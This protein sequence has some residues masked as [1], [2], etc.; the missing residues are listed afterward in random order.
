MNCYPYAKFI[1]LLPFGLL[2]AAFTSCTQTAYLPSTAYQPCVDTTN[3]FDFETGVTLFR[4]GA[5]GRVAFAVTNNLVTQGSFTYHNGGHVLSAGVTGQTTLGFIPEDRGTLKIMFYAGYANQIF[6]RDMKQY[7][8]QSGRRVGE[9]QFHYEDGSRTFE[10]HVTC[11]YN[12]FVLQP[13]LQYRSSDEDL[14]LD[15]GLRATCCYTSSFEHI[16]TYSYYTLWY[17]DPRYPLIVSTST[18]E[19]AAPPKQV[20]LVEPFVA[21]S[22]P[23]TNLFYTKFLFQYRCAMN[24]WPL[25]NLGRFDDTFPMYLDLTVGIHF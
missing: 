20:W 23:G 7:F 13:G 3:R 11:N 22:G 24:S 15:L 12:G 19:V 18:G 1:S 14:I 17:N 2:I 9:D 21:V 16:S 25:L 5:Y 6:H 10:Q 4:G 8:I